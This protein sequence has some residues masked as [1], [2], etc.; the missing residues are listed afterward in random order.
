MQTISYGDLM[1]ALE[2]SNVRELEDLLISDCFY[3]GIVKGKLDQRQRSLHVQEVIG[4]DVRMEELPLIMAGLGQWWVCGTASCAVGDPID[5]PPG[6]LE[7]Q[8]RCA[9]YLPT[10]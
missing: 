10:R 1:A 9:W 4:R 6:H 7:W 3:P 2:I 8:I 5:R